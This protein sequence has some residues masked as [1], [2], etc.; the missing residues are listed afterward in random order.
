MDSFDNWIHGWLMLGGWGMEAVF[1]LILAGVLGG[2]V[3]FER[4]LRGREA[5]FR[6]NI[7]V[8]LGC[9]LLMIVSTRFASMPWNPEG[10]YNI[11]VDPARIAYGVMTGIGFLGA[12]AII[13][14]FNGVRGLTTAAGLWCV[15]AIGLSCGLGL[16]IVSIFAAG[17]VLAALAMLNTIEKRLPRRRHRRLILRMPWKKGNIA[18][19]VKRFE[20]AG[21]AV[22][23]QN[24]H[25]HESLA[26]VDVTMDIGYTDTAKYEALEA[27][28]RE[29]TEWKLMVS[30]R[31]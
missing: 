9:S 13:K 21:I 4:E 16:Y 31:A 2:L 20:G 8:G 11:Q 27:E 18:E 22:I 28:L 10:A 30:E 14:H 25:R 29:G 7:L 5:G 6:T 23:D 24:Y 17:L 1:K 26:E 12:G 19:L 15:A 3:G